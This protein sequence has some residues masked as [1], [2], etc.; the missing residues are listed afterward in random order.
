MYFIKL[1]VLFH[2]VK[3]IILYGFMK[4]YRHFIEP[5]FMNFQLPN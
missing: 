5:N 3:Y 4:Q 2:I 1:N